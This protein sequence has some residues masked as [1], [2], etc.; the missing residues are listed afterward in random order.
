MYAACKKV[1]SEQ[2]LHVYVS[3]VVGFKRI[4]VIV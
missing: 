1:F 2:S 3:F 4:Y